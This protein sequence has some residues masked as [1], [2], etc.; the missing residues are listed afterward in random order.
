MQ[1][2]LKPPELLRFKLCGQLQFQVLRNHDSSL[3]FAALKTFK[4]QVPFCI[5]ET[6][7]NKEIEIPINNKI[8]LIVF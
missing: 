8:N 6:G 7:S 5:M 1:W 4:E 2:D 3:L